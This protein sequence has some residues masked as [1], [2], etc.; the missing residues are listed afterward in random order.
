M[1]SG[2]LWLGSANGPSGSFTVGDWES[3]NVIYTVGRYGI[4]DGGGIRIA[5]SRGGMAAQVDDSSGPGFTTISCN[6][7]VRLIGSS[8]RHI[9]PFWRAFQVTVRGGSLSEGDTIAVTFGDTRQ[10]SPGIRL[11]NIR[12]EEYLFKVFVDPF[13]S[14]LY[15]PIDGSPSIRVTGGKVNEIQVSAPSQVVA[16]VPFSVT[17]RALDRHGNRSDRYQ[18][19]VS[20][21]SEIGIPE[22]YVFTESDLGAHTF[23][24][25]VLC[26]LGLHN[27]TIS[28]DSGFT[29]I[30]NPIRVL[31]E[32]SELKLYWGDMHGQTKETVGSGTVPEYLSYLRDVAALDFGGWQGNDFQVTV[33]LWE[34]VKELIKLYHEPGRFITFLGYEWSGLTPG[35]GDHNIYYLGDDEPIYRSDQWLIKNKVDPETDRYPISEL[36]KTFKGRKDVLAIP[37]VGGRY[38]NYDYYNPEHIPLIEVHSNHGTFE[39][40]LEEAMKRRMKVGFIAASDD[41]TCRPGLTYPNGGMA[42]QGG[43]TA[44]YAKELTRE[45]LWEAFWARRTYGTT[46]EKILLHVES[47]GHLMGDEYSTA[48]SP[49]IKVNIIGTSTLHEVEVHNWEET[50]YRHPFAEP[51][52]EEEKLIKIEWS[53]ARVK[54]RPKIVNWN[55]GLTVEN[56]SIKDYKEFAFDHLYQGIEKVSDK[57]LKWTSS[58]GGDPDGVILELETTEETE[59]ILETAPITYKFNPNDIT[60]EPKEISAGGLNQKIKISTIKRE[61]PDTLNFTYTDK[62]A[63]KGL[64]AYWI[65]IVQSNGAMAWS[66]P[67]YIHHS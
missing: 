21:T 6:R 61:L 59:I 34:H 19:K 46:G 66:S 12:E 64:N 51:S 33:E 65:R 36:W 22:P 41:H 29:A 54:S 13:G 2:N 25:A 53:G 16:G 17:A 1:R 23:K 40:F 31:E 52:N 9:R 42:T 4:D 55:G 58:T 5:R 47:N 14:G 57:Q 28:D 44:V 30:S 15:K 50:I 60:Y 18:G 45:A 56:G 8:A 43:Y 24:N 27:L 48:N 35:G 63:S 38:G 3:F 67:I 20:F 62:T 7:D 37:H 49:K 10:G 39:W 26:S 11:K 32:E